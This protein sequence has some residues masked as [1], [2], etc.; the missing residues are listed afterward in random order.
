MFRL[1]Y[2]NLSI[3]ISFFLFYNINISFV[4]MSGKTSK[5]AYDIFFNIFSKVLQNS[6]NKQG[7]ILGNNMSS[8]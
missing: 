1:T 5:I 6:L 7:Y 8:D 4:K 2:L 3:G